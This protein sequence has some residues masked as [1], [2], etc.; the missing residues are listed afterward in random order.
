M[1]LDMY[2]LKIRSLTEKELAACVKRSK[3]PK[4]VVCILDAKLKG[5]PAELIF[6]LKNV[7]LSSVISVDYVDFNLIKE[8]C[9]IP[10]KW[11]Y[12]GT[13]VKGNSDG[14]QVIYTFSSNRL[15]IG[16]C[17]T[18]TLTSTELDDYTY[19]KK[20]PCKLFYEEEVGYWCKKYDLRNK[21]EELY[22]GVGFFNCGYHKCNREMRRLMKEYGANIQIEDEDIFFH[23]WY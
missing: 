11:M 23:E 21:L 15:G 6:D 16:E 12:V 22:D 3:L 7:Y 14:Q 13:S 4:N 10:S 1:G 2:A 19:S 8:D 20:E 9:G 18:V 5:R 17:K